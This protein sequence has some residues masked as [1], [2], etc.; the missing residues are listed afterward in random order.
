[1]P[2]HKNHKKEEMNMDWDKLRIFHAVARAGSFTNAGERLGLSQSAI[3]RQISNLELDL[4]TVLFHRH[5]RGLLLTEH[6]EALFATATE[7][8]RSLD[9]VQETLKND[10]EIPIGH[11]RLTATNG[12]GTRWLSSRIDQF[13]EQHPDIS[14]ELF[15]TEDEL[16][17]S[18]READVGIRMHRPTQPDL[19]Q[20]R[21]FTVHMHAY[22]S[23]KYAEKHG[24]P[25]NI[26][27][28]EG[29]Q[30]IGY[31][32]APNYLR[33]LNWLERIAH[34]YDV[35]LNQRVS[36]NNVLALRRLILNDLGI[37]ILPDYIMGDD[38]DLVQIDLDETPPVFEVYF[39]YPE[40]L[41]HSARIGALRDF[42]VKAAREWEF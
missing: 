39:C 12:L 41:R 8:S 16:D 26:I 1:M 36:V 11:I 31:T 25:K 3:S 32:N 6:G 28:L 33:D 30:F 42:L 27:D 19:I 9:K 37:A 10:K 15:L 40:E 24:V 13:L 35:S 34:E 14:V 20:K 17:L 18:M 5:A 38:V 21:L 23:K 2:P 29:H 4:K 7:I 22:C